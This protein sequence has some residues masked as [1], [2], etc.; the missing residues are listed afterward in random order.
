MMLWRFTTDS[1]G[2]RS[3]PF[4][5]LVFMPLL[6]A[7]VVD[8]QFSSGAP[9]P[10]PHVEWLQ[11]VADSDSAEG[12]ARLDGARQAAGEWVC[13]VGGASAVS[14]GQVPLLVQ[15]LHD[16][17]ASVVVVLAGPSMR[18]GHYDLATL[19]VGS[20]SVAYRVG[21]LR[22]CG[23]NAGSPAGPALFEWQIAAKCL[24]SSGA[25][26]AQVV[27]LEGRASEPTRS[28]WRDPSTYTSALDRLL[29]HL[30]EQAEQTSIA[31]KASPWLAQS[32]LGSL[33]WYFIVDGRA[34]APTVLVSDAM[35]PSF[36]ERIRRIV[37]HIG[38]A[39][40]TEM[41]FRP[42]AEEAQHA[43][44]SYLQ[45]PMVSPVVADAFDPVQKLIRLT[46]YVHG[47]MPAETFEVDGKPCHPAFAK[48][49]VCRF[50]RR[51]LY[52]QRIVWLPMDGGRKLTIMLNGIL[53]T[54]GFG[55]R[56]RLLTC[57]SPTGEALD[58]LVAQAAL[59]RPGRRMSRPVSGFG[60]VKVAALK[61]LAALVAA[62]SRFR[63]AWLFIDR[64]DDADD[65]A[66]HLYRW[67]RTNHPEINAWFLLDPASAD[68]S[69]LSGDGF[70]LLGPGIQRRMLV[71]NADHIV[72]SHDEYEHGGLDAR[73][74]GDA[75][76][77]RFSFVPHGISKDDVSHWLGRRDFDLFVTT[78]PA[79]HASIVGDET[80]YSYTAREVQ[81]LGLPRR[82]A[83]LA[84][85][86]ETPASDVNTLL[87][88]PT[89]RGHLVDE[90]SAASSPEAALTEFAASEYAMQWRAL[91]N[92]PSLR[93]MADT[94]GQ[95]IAFMAHPNAAPFLAAF[96]APAHVEVLTKATAR[97][98]PLLARSSAI[99]TDYTSVAFEMAFL[100]RGVF[101]YQF[102]RERFYGGDHNWRPGYFDYDRDGFGPV[103]FDLQ[104]LLSAIR[105]FL[106][107]D[108]RPNAVY[109]SRMAHAMP[110]VTAGACQRVFDA[111]LRLNQAWH[112]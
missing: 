51:D 98:M 25:G 18:P 90:R 111:L 94:H 91:L 95:R 19:P 79:E 57:A 93:E 32:A 61:R 28:V 36:H 110:N 17:D 43:L 75:L 41:P 64:V 97:F 105:A 60:A 59:P 46:Y 87:V 4:L 81:Y 101:Y 89:W 44:L 67:V 84:K 100:R 38:A 85:V 65:N 104:T 1:G 5:R 42:E 27:P 8:A 34:R 68:W 70:R 49:R 10:L 23:L 6:T 92:S 14:A 82:D 58:L 78:S 7:V 29:Y 11:I 33:E 50:F 40:I 35:A 77:F 76:R 31:S 74:Y 73:L 88:M 102:D 21:A 52:R 112:P 106:E 56:S 66:E 80:P 12:Q 30:Q 47:D 86:Q 24:R 55:L 108:A 26:M 96:E 83:L 3:A 15:A 53:T 39:A 37:M 63:N 99:I 2:A 69:R 72:S 62:R 16:V 48:V 107:N 109:M 9:Q 54:V 45:A 13:F 71:L 20:V 22:S 103:A